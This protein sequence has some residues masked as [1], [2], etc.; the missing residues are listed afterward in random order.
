MIEHVARKGE[1][2]APILRP[3]RRFESVIGFSETPEAA[4]GAGLVRA[5]FGNGG[6]RREPQVRFDK[7]GDFGDGTRSNLP[8][9][10]RQR[11]S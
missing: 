10:Y 9:S 1:T 8:R 11:A 3:V 6:Y 4:A 5:D 7:G 2:A